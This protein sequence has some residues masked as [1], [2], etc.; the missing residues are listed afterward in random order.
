MSKTILYL[1][2]YFRTPEE[3]GALR[4]YHI[5]SKMAERGFDVHMITTCS[6]KSRKKRKVNGFHVHYLPIS[7]RNSFSFLRRITSFSRFVLAAI[8]H[9]RRIKNIE[10]VYATSTPLTVGIIAV[11]IKWARRVPFIFEVRDLW[12]L[13]PIQLGILK[14]KVAIYIAQFLEKKCYQR[15]TKIIALSPSMTKEITKEVPQ[16]KCLTIPNFSDNGF[17]QL[18][19]RPSSSTF[20]IGYFGSL[21]FTNDVPFLIS[22][23]RLFEKRLPKIRFVLAGEGAELDNL[24]NVIASEKLANVK[25]RGYLNSYEI[26]KALEG[27]D[28]CLTLFRQ[29][30]V[31]E[32]N[33]PNKL[34]D[35]L[36]SG[37]LC[38]V[39]TRGWL[40]ELVELNE[41][42]LYIDPE[43]IEQIPNVLEPFTS[44]HDLLVKY[45]HNARNLAERKFDKKLLTNQLVDEIQS[46]L[47]D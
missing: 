37:K 1:H 26:K 42:G 5:A 25:I 11:W 21:G 22:L 31:L 16:E 13:A 18:E 28:A 4:S 44:N 30:P 17:F 32:T 34:F 35:G 36:A 24:K 47:E 41:C 43:N 15:A 23:I 27:V 3:G 9:S 2:Q 7:Y 8:Q 33:S 45:Q 39:N 38:I 10:L 46:L 14:S 40:K 29:F 12:P 6:E 19:P 20:T